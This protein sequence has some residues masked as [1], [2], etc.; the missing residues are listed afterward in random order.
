M[1]TN[2]SIRY[3]NYCLYPHILGRY[4]IAALVVE[5]DEEDERL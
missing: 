1:A 4:S 5:E 2:I 3:L